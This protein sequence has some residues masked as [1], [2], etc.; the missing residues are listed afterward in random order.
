MAGHSFVNILKTGIFWGIHAAC[1]GVIWVGISPIAVGVCLALYFVRM[2]AITGGYHRYFSH[3]TYKTSRLFQFILAF[4]GA[5][6]AQ[7][8]PLWWAGHHRHHHRHSDTDEDIHPP[9]K[10]LWWAHVGW[11]V[12]TEYLEPRAHE[13]KDL[14]RYPELRF[15]D[16]W[17]LI[18]PV[19]LGISMFALGV[20]LESAGFNTNGWQM[21]IWGFFVSTTLVYHGT[22]VI[23]SLTHK[24]GRRRF[25]TTDNSRNSLI[26]SL[27]TLGEG[28]HNNHHRYPGSER[29]GFY[30][31]EVDL[32]HYAL[33]VLS[34]FGMVWDLRK[35]PAHIY[36]E[37]RS[38]Q[39][40][41]RHA[42]QTH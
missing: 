3:R 40:G 41:F 21:L 19:A 18:A 33:T 24:W 16:E 26:L 8:G 6:A 39:L 32:T 13:V 28:W 17:H 1:L 14:A 5:S 27:I 25:A 36:E 11:V 23:N 38:M 42:G 15:I 12:S 20:G 31:W 7:K 37:A 2:F 10:G 22:F 34:W 35:P 29:Q 4:A 9:S 30:W